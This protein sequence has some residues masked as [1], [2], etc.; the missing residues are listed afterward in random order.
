MSGV[1]VTI[2]LAESGVIEE[3]INEAIVDMGFVPT[4]ALTVAP[5]A[6]EAGATYAKN[7]YVL[8]GVQIYRS[9]AAGNKGHEPKADADFAT[10]AP[11]SITLYLLQNPNL[12][13][14]PVPLKQQA[15]NNKPP[16][17]SAATASQAEVVGTGAETPV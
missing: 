3:A 2:T 10:W 14:T 17:S 7:A 11:V 15:H 13:A 1:D 5:P 8:E 12:L 4:A 9:Q 16:A 6:Y